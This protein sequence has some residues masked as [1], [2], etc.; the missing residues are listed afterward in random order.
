MITQLLIDSRGLLW[1]AKM[2]GIDVYDEANDKMYHLYNMPTMACALVEDCHGDIWATQAS[3]AHSPPIHPGQ[4]RRNDEWCRRLHHQAIQLRPDQPAHLQ[5]DQVATRHPYRQEREPEIKQIE[6]TSVDE[7]L[8]K[9]ATKYIE[10]NLANTELSVEMMSAHLGMSRVNL[11]KRMLSVTGKTPSE[12]IRAIRLM[13]AEPL[14]RECKY[15]V[16][17]VAYKVGFNNPRYF[18]KYFFETYGIYPSQYKNTP[19]D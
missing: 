12:F 13:H 3:D 19:S 7:Q 18:S 6:I 2:S 14:L 5:P 11:Y 4:D 10:N 1:C 8:V 15:N 16:S 9:D 17:E